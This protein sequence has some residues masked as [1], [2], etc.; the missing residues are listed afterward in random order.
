MPTTLDPKTHTYTDEKGPLSG[1]T[2][3]LG[4]AGLIDFS[5]IPEAMRGHYMDRGSKVHRATEL[6]DEDDLD[7]SSVD[8]VLAGYLDAYVN[9]VDAYG[10]RYKIIKSEVMVTHP[11]QRYA[12][13][14]DRLCIIDGELAILDI[15]SGALQPWVALQLEAYRVAHNAENV[16]KIE[17]R[18]ALSL[19]KEGK[20]FLKKYVNPSD[21]SA[22]LAVVTLARWKGRIK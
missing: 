14:Y 7:A 4:D 6:F 21:A 5:M 10:D 20:Y 3:L 11:V 19:S 8:P 16:D 22:W 13:Q 18:Y 2:S 17:A 15:K 12:G 9:F 1:V